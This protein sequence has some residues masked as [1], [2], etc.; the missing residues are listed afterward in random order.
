MAERPWPLDARRIL[1][2]A[3][4]HAGIAQ[5]PIGGGEAAIDLVAAEA[6]E[7]RQQR[8]PVRA[9]AAVAVHHLVENAGQRPV[10][11]NELLQRGL[12]LIGCGVELR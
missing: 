6:R 3:I 7:H 8:L 12:L 5:I 10:A 11:G 2:D 1:V 9:H 4:E